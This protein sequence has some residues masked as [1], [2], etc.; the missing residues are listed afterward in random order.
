V[1]APWWVCWIGN[2]RPSSEQD[3]RRSATILIVIE[4]AGFAVVDQIVIGVDGFGAD[5]K[6]ARDEG[7]GYQEREI[8]ELFLRLP[9]PAR[10][11]AREVI[12]ALGRAHG[13][14]P[15]AVPASS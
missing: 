13:L 15:L 10:K 9:V 3:C 14:V 5:D 2:Q 12:V 8:F 7:I 1:R 4:L 6:V 11:V